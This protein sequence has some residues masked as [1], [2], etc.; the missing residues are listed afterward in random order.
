MLCFTR[1]FVH[2]I[3]SHKNLT[4]FHTWS[5]NPFQ[6]SLVLDFLITR[7]LLIADNTE[8]LCLSRIFFGIIKRDL[9]LE[10]RNKIVGLFF[11]FLVC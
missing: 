3:I 9:L 1:L 7:W 8:C 6:L 10:F 11:F 4:I 2:A 5:L